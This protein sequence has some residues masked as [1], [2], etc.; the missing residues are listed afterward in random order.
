MIASP[1]SWAPGGSTPF[2]CCYIPIASVHFLIISRF[3]IRAFSFLCKS[4]LICPCPYLDYS[5]LYVSFSSQNKSYKTIPHLSFLFH[6]FTQRSSSI[7]CHV[8]TIQFQ[9]LSTPL[10]SIQFLFGLNQ[11]ATLLLHSISLLTSSF[12]RHLLSSLFQVSAHQHFALPFHLD[13]LY[14]WSDPYHF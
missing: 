13:T 11:Y 3:L 10:Y 12:P 7:P 5:A 14:R 4:K 2:H 6:F 9:L 1:I 8:Y